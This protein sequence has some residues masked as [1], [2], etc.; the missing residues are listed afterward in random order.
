MEKKTFAIML[1]VLLATVGGAFAIRYF[2]TNAVANVGLGQLPLE[3]GEWIG[4][5]ETL[6]SSILALLN[7]DQLFTATYV[8]RSGQSVNLFVDYFSPKNRAGA[9]HSPRNCL[10]GSGWVIIKSEPR[11]IM[12]AGK[13]IP[14]SRFYLRLGESL[15]I[16]DFWYVTRLGE[17]ANDYRLKFNTMLSSLTLRPTDKAFIRFVSSADPRSVAAMEEFERL[18]IAEIYNRLPFGSVSEPISQNQ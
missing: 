4:Q 6:P 10:P 16:M 7:P 3:K 18:F 17:T 13:S 15:Q 5:V 8:N 2:Q 11:P 14:A 9:I 1:A 12:A